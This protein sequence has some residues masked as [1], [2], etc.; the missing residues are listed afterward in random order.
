MSQVDISKID[1]VKELKA[2]AYDLSVQA[3]QLAQQLQLVQARIA[4]VESEVQDKKK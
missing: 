2:I 1:D 3:Q 4:Q